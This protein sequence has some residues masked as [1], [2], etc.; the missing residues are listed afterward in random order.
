MVKAHIQGIFNCTQGQ[1]FVGF[2]QKTGI[3]QDQLVEIE[4]LKGSHFHLRIELDEKTF[5]QYESC[6]ELASFKSWITAELES[7]MEV[8]L[9][10]FGG[11]CKVLFKAIGNH[12]IHGLIKT[13]D[14]DEFEIW[15]MF[16]ENE[17]IQKISHKR[18][19]LT[20]TNL[21]KRQIQTNLWFQFSRA[22][23][24]NEFYQGLSV[25]T[26]VLED[27]NKEMLHFDVTPMELKMLQKRGTKNYVYKFQFGKETAYNWGEL[28]RKA[29]ITQIG[30]Q[31]FLKVFKGSNDEHEEWTLIFTNW[32]LTM[33]GLDLK[34]GH[35]CQIVYEHASNVFGPSKM[36]AN[37]GLEDFGLALSMPK[38][39]IEAL[40]TDFDAIWTLTEEQNG[41]INY[42]VD[43]KV[44]PK[45]INYE[46]GQEF[47]DEMPG[48]EIHF[49]VVEMLQ[50][51][52][53]TTT[54]KSSY[55]CLNIESVFKVNFVI[56]TT[57]V[58]G[59]KIVDKTFLERL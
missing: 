15:N 6:E 14:M 32:G 10:V 45:N 21:W 59:T 50:N 42:K 47:E 58:V 49:K 39:V 27:V 37:A 34:S 29:A 43:S 18:S 31:K 13:K 23:N 53:L 26:K 55:V 48:L 25:P 30:P 41:L 36:I 3:Q 4:K 33:D 40:K 28:K 24:L 52:T 57:R 54:F 17:L 7:E 1:D 12:T 35:Q 38:D 22:E 51:N 46:F 8:N 44:M 5:Y 20:H 19:G 11:D 16:H 2:F 9:P 56:I